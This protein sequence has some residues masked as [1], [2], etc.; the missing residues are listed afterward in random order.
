[1]K[2]GHGIATSP[3]L[4][5]HLRLFISAFFLSTCSLTLNLTTFCRSR[6]MATRNGIASVV[7]LLL[8]TSFLTALA[9]DTNGVE[10]GYFGS[11]GPKH[12]GR[13]NPNFTR[14]AKGMTQS[15]ID[16]KTDEVV[17]N[18]SLGRLHRDYAAANATL[19]D[20]IFNIALRYED[21]PGTV[22]IDGVKYTLKNIHWHSPS[23]HT[24]NGQRFAVEQHMVHISDAGNVTVVSILYRLGRPEP[25]LMQIQDKLSELYVEACRAEKGAPIPAGVVSMW[26]LRRYTHAYYRYVGSLTTPPCT[27]NIIW[28]ILG[29]VREMTMEQAAALIAPLEK[30]YRRNNRPTQQLNGRTVQVYRRFWKNKTNETP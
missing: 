1:M 18:P 6:K 8:F 4:S 11:L 21:A 17:Y 25:F 28:N 13:L 30:G 12:W 29:Q 16:I 26:S 9:C 5:I 7:A 24:I 10:F 20:N 14:C 2:I 3:C 27:E 19:V 15:P 23:E 22:D